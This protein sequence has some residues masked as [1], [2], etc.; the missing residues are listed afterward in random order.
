[1]TKTAQTQQALWAKSIGCVFELPLGDAGTLVWHA[2]LGGDT[3]KWDD[4]FYFAVVTFTTIGYG[5]LAPSGH[6]AKLFFIVYVILTLIVQLT[7]LANF[8]NA[9]AEMVAESSS[10]T[11]QDGPESSDVRFCDS[12][13]S[14]RLHRSFRTQTPMRRTEHASSC[15]ILGEIVQFP[16][17]EMTQR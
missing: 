15:H 13:A 16:Y 7:V 5:D 1:M 6:W 14:A 12:T 17:L 10:D 2:L 8:V 11:A 4:A 9:A 3:K